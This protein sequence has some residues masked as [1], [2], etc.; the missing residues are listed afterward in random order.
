LH[1]GE[2]EQLLVADQKCDPLAGDFDSARP[3]KAKG[4]A[5]AGSEGTPHANR[6]G[7]ALKERPW[8]LTAD[9]QRRI[10]VGRRVGDLRR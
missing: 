10:F 1:A 8:L 2:D 3:T 5:G 6:N 4:Y 9:N 7:S